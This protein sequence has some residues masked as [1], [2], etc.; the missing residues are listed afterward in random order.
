MT[1]LK[2]VFFYFYFEIILEVLNSLKMIQR[3]P[4]YHL[5]I[6]SKL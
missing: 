2:L 4:V 5:S 6:F 1:V 3:I